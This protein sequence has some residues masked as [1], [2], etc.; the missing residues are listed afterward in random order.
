MAARLLEATD[1]GHHEF[2]ADDISLLQPGNADWRQVIG[3]KQI[4]DVY[5]LALAVQ[6]AGRFVTFDSRIAL[7]VVAAAGKTNLCVI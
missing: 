5:L 6:R 2:W 4:T 3:A 7:T 1:T